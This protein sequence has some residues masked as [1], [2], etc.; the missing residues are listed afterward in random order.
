LEEEICA[1]LDQYTDTT[2]QS[3]TSYPYLREAINAV[4]S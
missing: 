1:H 2:V 4:C 3:L